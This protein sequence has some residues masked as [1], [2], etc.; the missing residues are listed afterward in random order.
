MND[1]TIRRLLDAPLPELMAEAA[2]VRDEGHPR[3]ITFSPKVLY[4]CSFG[5]HEVLLLQLLGFTA[6][7]SNPPLTTS[8]CH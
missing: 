4:C 8:V 1:S 5:Y 7:W 6:S 2:A 3:V